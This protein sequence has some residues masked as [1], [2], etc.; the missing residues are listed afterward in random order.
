MDGGGDAVGVA[1]PWIPDQV[2]DGGVGRWWRLQTG[3]EKKK[4]L[5]QPSPAKAGEG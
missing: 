4:A 1:F 2:R 3:R 5:T